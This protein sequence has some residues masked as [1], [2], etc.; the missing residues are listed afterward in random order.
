MPFMLFDAAGI[1]LW[2]LERKAVKRN[3]TAE[4]LKF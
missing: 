3:V 1:N 2:S 4:Y